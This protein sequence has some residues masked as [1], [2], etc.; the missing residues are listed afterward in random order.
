[1][2][3]RSQYERGPRREIASERRVVPSLHPSRLVQPSNTDDDPRERAAVPAASAYLVLLLLRLPQ[4]HSLA[5]TVLQP[6]P[7]ATFKEQSRIALEPGPSV[8]RTAASFPSSI[9]FF[10]FLKPRT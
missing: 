1:M 3:A 10:F 4:S 9:N 5:E 7:A 2:A 8:P 6:R